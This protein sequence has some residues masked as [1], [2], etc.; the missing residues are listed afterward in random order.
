MN[1][2]DLSLYT[3]EE[4]INELFRRSTFQGVLIHGGG[5]WKGRW[6]G[7][8]TFKV[9]FNDNLDA[10]EVRRLLEVVGDHL[11]AHG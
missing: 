3:S 7:M 5:D 4:L 2:E 6:E 11:S 8:R 10:E 9:S 1:S